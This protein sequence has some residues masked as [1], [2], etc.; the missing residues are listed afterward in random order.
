MPYNAPEA[1]L[2]NKKISSGPSLKPLLEAFT[3]AHAKLCH[4]C[5]HTRYMYTV[6]CSKDGLNVNDI[7]HNGKYTNTILLI[8]M[9]KLSRTSL[10]PVNGNDNWTIK[11][12]LTF[13]KVHNFL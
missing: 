2:T 9:Y 4:V 1:K 5:Q 3:E 6:D 8:T 13:T 10:Y 11:E 7:I 12:R